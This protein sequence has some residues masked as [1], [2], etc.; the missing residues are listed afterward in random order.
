MERTISPL[1]CYGQDLKDVEAAVY[2][3][4]VNPHSLNY[5]LRMSSPLPGITNRLS[6]ASNTSD[7][8]SLFAWQKTLALEGTASDLSAG[9]RFVQYL[10]PPSWYGSVWIVRPEYFNFLIFTHRCSSNQLSTNGS[11]AK[12]SS[13]FKFF[14]LLTSRNGQ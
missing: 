10:P 8:S 11:L 5:G 13:L 3:T 1:E 6:R 9:C 14:D 4:E 12:R 7:F 2:V